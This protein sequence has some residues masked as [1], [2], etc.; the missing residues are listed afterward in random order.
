MGADRTADNEPKAADAA[1]LI[2]RYS[3]IHAA[4][5]FRSAETY[6]ATYRTAAARAHPDRAG[7]SHDAFVE[8]SRAKG[9]LDKHHGALSRRSC[10]FQAGMNAVDPSAVVTRIQVYGAVLVTAGELA[11]RA[12]DPALVAP[13]TNCRLSAA[14]DE[15]FTASLTEILL[16]AKL[17]FALRT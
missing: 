6:R 15:A 5:I 11:P 8:L 16:I 7:G 10:Y 17:P 4:D 1:V 9:I 3:G 12:A 13:V 2:E 14:K